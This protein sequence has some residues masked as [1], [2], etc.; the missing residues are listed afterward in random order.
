MYLTQKNHI[1]C[2]KKTYRI[3]RILTRLSKNL[4]NFTLY[5]VRQYYFNNG[6]YLPYEQAYH[7]VKHNENYQLLPSQVAQ[8]V[9]KV[10]DRN[11]K[12]FFHVL[13]ERRKGNYNRP[14]HPPRYLPKDG[15][16]VCI[17]QKDMF[18]VDGEKI[19]LSLGRNFTKEFGVRYLEF[20]LPKTV[21]GKKIKEVRII[22]RCKGLWFEIEHV[23]EVEPEKAD[24]DYSKYL[25]I[26]LGVDNFATCVSTSGTPFI[27]EGRGLKSFNR[28]WNKEKAKLQSVYDKQSI[29]MGK[30]MAWL[31][32]K[33]RNFVN[34]FLNQA[35]NYIIKY[36]L[37]HKIGN[38]VVGELKEIK[39]NLDLGKVNNQNIQYIPWGVFKQ[40]LRFKCEYYGISYIEVDENGTS[41]TCA[42]CGYKDKKNRE[43]RG[44]FVCRKCG[45]VVNADVNGALNILKKVAPESVRIGGSGG[46]TPPRRIRVVPLRSVQTPPE[47]PYFSRE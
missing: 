34:N 41:I 33:R 12:S 43:H 25:A 15:Y 5:T 21:I 38:I 14:V 46:V 24:L 23:Y 18:K 37:A 10:V 19:R 27:I 35:V 13:R 36:C 9:M 45:F 29:K 40:K 44:L 22:P 11:M 17:F 42:R 7:L 1:R 6:K 3:L 4:Y 32:R 39:Q 30:K 16:F 2:D 20:K 28:W 31:L 26:D 8:Q 47:A